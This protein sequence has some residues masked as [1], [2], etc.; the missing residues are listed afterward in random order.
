MNSYLNS[1]VMLPSNHLPCADHSVQR[2]VILILAQVKAINEKL[3]G[4]LVS[5]RRSKDLRQ[6]Y[7]L[8]AERL[9][10]TSKE[11]TQQDSPTCWNSTHEMCSN[12][13]KMRKALDHTIMMQHCDNLGTGPLTDLEWTK[14]SAV[15][16]FLRIPR[17]VKKSL[18]ADRKSS[19]DLVQL[20]IAH[21]IKHCETNKVQLQ[22]VD[23]LV[24]AMNMKAKLELYQTKLVQLPAIVAGYLNPQIPKPSDCAKLQQLKDRIRAVLREHDADKMKAYEPA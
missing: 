1:K 23:G 6:S 12:V 21:L 4:A 8:E 14:V 2:G 5:T 15:M 9:G 18:A 10:Y 7:C 19:L 16:N 11:P 13:L 24:L 20:S 3:Q 17:Q 22:D